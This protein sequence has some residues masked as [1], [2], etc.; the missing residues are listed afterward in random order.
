MKFSQINLHKHPSQNWSCFPFLIPSVHY[1]NIS[2][3]VN[4][5]A[6]IYGVNWTGSAFIHASPEQRTWVVWG[7]Q[8]HLAALPSYC[9]FH[10]DTIKVHVQITCANTNL[11]QTSNKRSQRRAQTDPC[12]VSRAQESNRRL[13]KDPRLSASHFIR[14]KACFTFSNETLEDLRGTRRL[15]CLFFRG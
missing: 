5:I 3:Q 11:Q 14:L 6:S 4:I 12:V 15:G 9:S 2:D 10:R 7:Y 1:A 8:V 13:W